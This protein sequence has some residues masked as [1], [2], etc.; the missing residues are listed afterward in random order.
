[1]GKWGK[2]ANEANGANGANEVNEVN[3]QMAI[4][5]L[6]A[7]C[8]LPFALCILPFAFCHLNTKERELILR[9][10]LR[11]GLFV[12]ISF[13]MPVAHPERA[14]SLAGTPWLNIV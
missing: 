4:K 12:E 5:P 11:D 2:W 9:C 1:M 14:R 13:Q 6:S 10:A 3:G 7:L 8:R